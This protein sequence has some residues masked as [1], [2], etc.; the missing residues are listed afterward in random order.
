MSVGKE[1][2]APR[3][4]LD[5]FNPDNFL[6][7]GQSSASSTNQSTVDTLKAQTDAITASAD[8]QNLK[9]KS[10]TDVPFYSPPYYN[11]T[12][13]LTGYLNQSQ[14]FQI[15][16]ILASKY[17]YLVSVNLNYIQNGTPVTIQSVTVYNS[18]TSTYGGWS[19]PDAFNTASANPA[20]QLSFAGV[21]TDAKPTLT[22]T[23][24][25]TSTPS[26]NSFTA[27]GNFT[28]IGIQTIK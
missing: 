20:I 24:G 18:W 8:A 2:Y 22:F 4:Q 15:P 10:I 19:A 16:Y 21:G 23:Y 11:E 5:V 12:I 6:S 25:Y 17:Y 3:V 1:Y 13:T 27:T 28:I 26:T 9:F 14:T 7:I